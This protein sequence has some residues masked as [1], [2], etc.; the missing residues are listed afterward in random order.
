MLALILL[1]AVPTDAC[2][3]KNNQAAMTMCE[4]AL[5]QQADA[6]M[7]AVWKRLLP[8]MRKLDQDPDFG[9]AQPG[10]GYAASL[11]AAQRA[12]LTWR[13]AE[14]GIESYE[15]RGGTVQPFAENVCRAKVTQDRIRQLR[16]MLKWTGD[17]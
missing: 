17:R 8:A 16:Y 15:W 7:N 6:T 11:L 1:A 3:A 4:G 5:S 10:P 2:G 14:C 13:E 12:W 9:K